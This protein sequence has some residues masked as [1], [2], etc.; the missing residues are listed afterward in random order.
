MLKLGQ[1]L[2]AILDIKC[3]ILNSIPSKPTLLK[4]AVAL[5]AIDHQ[6]EVIQV[7]IGKTFIED[8]L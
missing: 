8:V 1:L 6:M 2:W 3:Y 7:Q 5:I 4:L